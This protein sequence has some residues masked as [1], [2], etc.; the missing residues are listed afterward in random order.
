MDEF[1]YIKGYDGIYKINRNGDVLCCK[2]TEKLIKTQFDKDGYRICC[3]NQQSKKLHRLLAIQ[4]IPNDDP[5]KI[6]ID[7]IDRNRSNNDLAN[8][9]WTN[10]SEQMRNK[11]RSGCISIHKGFR[12]N[13]EPFINYRGSYT[14]PDETGKMKVVRKSSCIDIKIVEDWLNDIKEQY[15]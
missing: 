15:P 12:K 5:T 6:E 14:I 10:R 1:E 4:F 11:S 13:G 2:K 7:H 8:L 9:K 3:L